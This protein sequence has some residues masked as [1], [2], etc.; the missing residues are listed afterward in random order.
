MKNAL[1]AFMLLLSL[2]SHAQAGLYDPQNEL[3]GNGKPVQLT[4]PTKPFVDVEIRSFPAQ[5]TID[6][7]ANE[8]VVAV[9]VDENLRP[10]LRI[11]DEGGKLILSFEHP[12]GKLFWI[13]S[14][15]IKINI[16]TPELKKLTYQ[17]NSNLV[18]NNLHGESL[19]M[20][21]QGNATVALLGSIK[22]MNLTNGAN[23][24]IQ[25]EKLTTQKTNVVSRANGSV[26]VH[27]KEVSIVNTG[28]GSV[29]NVAD[30]LQKDNK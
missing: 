18:V 13:N 19:D 30:S 3:R 1:V 28:L 25:A 16:K 8:S 12:Q 4:K 27:A 17:S 11:D 29:V 5:I 23:G 9:T 20:A 14:N 26:R 2:N 6:A 24:T 7:G 21:N 15:L 22:T 10:L